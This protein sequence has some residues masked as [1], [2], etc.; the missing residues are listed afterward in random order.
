M[1]RSYLNFSA[2]Y[3]FPKKKAHY[4]DISELIDDTNL[5]LSPRRPVPTF[6]NNYDD[7]VI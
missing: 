3:L 5:T 4:P 6:I 7:T 2:F 1:R